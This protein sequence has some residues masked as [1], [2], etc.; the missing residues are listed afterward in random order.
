[1]C[2]IG[3]VDDFFGAVRKFQS[4]LLQPEVLDSINRVRAGANELSVRCYPRFFISPD[5]RLDRLRPV[6]TELCPSKDDNR[7]LPDLQQTH[8][9]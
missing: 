8:Q 4:D 6:N 3:R 5:I 1:M 2:V 7:Y 9:A